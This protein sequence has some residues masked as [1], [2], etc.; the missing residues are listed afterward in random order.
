VSRY[1]SWAAPGRFVPGAAA[2]ACGAL[3][4]L[5]TA[6]LLAWS[7]SA[8]FWLAGLA[9]L[10]GF[11]VALC[12]NALTHLAAMRLREEARRRGLEERLKRVLDREDEEIF[13]AKLGRGVCQ[14]AGV[15]A[16][17]VGLFEAD[18]AGPVVV[19]TAVLAAALFP[20]VF[21]G[22]PYLLAL[23][24][25]ERLLLSGLLFYDRAAAPLRPLTRLLHRLSLRLVRPSRAVDPSEELKDEILSAVEEGRR[26]G[27][28][29]D[30]ERKMIEGVIDLHAV[31]AAEIMTPRTEMVSVPLEAT[32]E[33]AA[34]VAV[35]HGLSRL[36]V[37]R[38]NPDDIAG[39]FYVRD[40]L[41]YWLR[42]EP[43]PP[44]AKVMRQPF[45]VPSSKS[46][47]EL[48]HDMRARQVH[49]AVVLDE[50][51]G[52]GGV[53]TLEDVLEEIVGEISDEHE[54]GGG[55]EAVRIDDEGATVRA[56]TAIEELNRALGLSVPESEEYETIG[57]L[58]LSRMGKI[59]VKGEQ[60]DLDGVCF[61]VVD[62]D[63]RRINRVKVTVRGDGGGAAAPSGRSA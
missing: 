1:K 16:L 44:L 36:P 15:A 35:D 21:V 8:W 39:I 34:Q 11:F 43:P 55:E 53:V 31:T 5:A 28:L 52:T 58:L 7:P 3:P 33:Q 61:T 22:L 26:E 30:V 38:G 29:E 37:R 14:L 62:A 4:P 41:P 47:Q 27:L 57:G 48:L 13:G 51:G 20:L 46:V 49:L 6:P 40:L 19:A 32:A 50:Y 54:R 60:Y 9:L 56:G 45:F 2:R 12:E 10:A 63:E 18:P 23:R 59:P 42:R 25:S 24:G 17:V